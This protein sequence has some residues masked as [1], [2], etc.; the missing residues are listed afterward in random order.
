MNKLTY[1]QW[2][3]EVEAKVEKITGL[4]FDMLPDWMSRDCYEMGLSV[5]DGV[6][7]CIEQ[8]GYREFAERLVDEG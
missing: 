7:I 6:D 2:M 8:I 1:R 4:G 5:R 3:T